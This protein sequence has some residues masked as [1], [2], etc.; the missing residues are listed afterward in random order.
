MSASRPPIWGRC[1][2]IL[3]PDGHARRTALAPA[4]RALRHSPCFM[5]CGFDSTHGS[6]RGDRSPFALAV[7]APPSASRTRGRG[8]A[9]F[10]GYGTRE[11]DPQKVGRTS[12]PAR[13]RRSPFG[14][15]ARKHSRCRLPANFRGSAR[16][17]PEG[18]SDDPAPARQAGDAPKRAPP[19]PLASEPSGVY[20]CTRCTATR[21]T[22]L[23]VRRT[24]L[25]ALPLSM[26]PGSEVGCSPARYGG[27]GW[28]GRGG[29]VAIEARRW[30]AELVQGV[31]GRC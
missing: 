27:G 29:L 3:P 24:S 5:S 12:C 19:R 31:D 23:L 30:L 10:V 22:S 21:V 25:P 16:P 18:Q 28:L 15:C 17:R 9:W 14:S 7:R 13:P 26:R 6:T 20:S 4:E 8:V 2:A 1:S 11:R